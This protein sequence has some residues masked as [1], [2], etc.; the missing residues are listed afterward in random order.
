M[1]W[2][3][4]ILL[5]KDALD[6]GRLSRLLCGPEIALEVTVTTL[7]VKSKI[8]LLENGVPGKEID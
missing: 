2:K 6:A 1:S 7:S 5:W 8:S 4:E 3:L